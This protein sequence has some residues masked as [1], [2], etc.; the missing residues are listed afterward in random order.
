MIASLMM[1]ITRGALMLLMTY[2]IPN[3]TRRIILPTA[4][5]RRS[6]N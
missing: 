4:M 6:M 3:Q 5:G 1:M 2:Q